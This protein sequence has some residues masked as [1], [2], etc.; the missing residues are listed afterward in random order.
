MPDWPKLVEGVQIVSTFPKICR[1]CECGSDLHRKTTSR[2][3]SSRGSGL[4]VPWRKCLSL[5]IKCRRQF[6][7]SRQTGKWTEID[8]IVAN[9]RGFQPAGS[10][11]ADD[12]FVPF[13]AAYQ[14]LKICNLRCLFR[15]V[16]SRDGHEMAAARDTDTL[17]KTNQE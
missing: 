1:E 2:V 12:V 13:G 6:P 8:T 14:V 3:E 15:C 17:G 9:G 7:D 11:S 4:A 16:D 5:A 10:Q